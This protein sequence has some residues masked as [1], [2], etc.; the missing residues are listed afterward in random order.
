MAPLQ[1][2]AEALSG[3][4]GILLHPWTGLTWPQNIMPATMPDVQ[5]RHEALPQLGAKAPH[6]VVQLGGRYYPCL[7][8]TFPTPSFTQNFVCLLSLQRKQALT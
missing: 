1:L 3:R 7:A 2:C 5:Y 4:G 6:P 8:S